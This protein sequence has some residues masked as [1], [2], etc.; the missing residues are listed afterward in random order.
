M[1]STTSTQSI[2]TTSCSYR[3]PQSTSLVFQV[4]SQQRQTEGDSKASCSISAD[5]ISLQ[6]TGENG[7]HA[8]KYVPLY[9]SNV[10]ICFTASGYKQFR[11][12]AALNGMPATFISDDE[13]DEPTNSP[14]EGP[15][16]MT[17][18]NAPADKP[19][20]SQSEGVTTDFTVNPTVIPSDDQ[21]EPLLRSDQAALM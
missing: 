21:D 6:W 16:T 14:D 20:R 17:P 10:G 12:F 15:I 11:A 9:K 4:F 1:T 7:K 18:S 13:E 8:N 19:P 2:F 5:S 3:K